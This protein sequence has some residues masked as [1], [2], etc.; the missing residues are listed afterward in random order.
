[1]QVFGFGSRERAAL[2]GWRRAR[3]AG[4]QFLAAEAGF[5][6]LCLQSSVGVYTLLGSLQGL[7]AFFGRGACFIVWEMGCLKL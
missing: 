7:C 6:I 4:K 3:V 1:M 2:Q 5:V